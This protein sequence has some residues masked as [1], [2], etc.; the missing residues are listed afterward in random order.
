MSKLELEH[1]YQNYLDDRKLYYVSKWSGGEVIVEEFI[2]SESKY[3]PYVY[4]DEDYTT[5]LE[6]FE[7]MLSNGHI[8]DLGLLG[9]SGFAFQEV[10]NNIDGRWF[11]YNTNMVL[12][13]DRT[14]DLYDEICKLDKMDIDSFLSLAR[15]YKELL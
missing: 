9:D 12:V 11:G 10:Y 15:K 7:N 4:E 2:Q 8:R 14:K 5:D 3:Y 1:V 6:I 13:K